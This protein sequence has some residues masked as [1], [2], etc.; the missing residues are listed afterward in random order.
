[1]RVI[2]FH[3]SGTISLLIINL[4]ASLVLRASASDWPQWR[5][6]HRDGKSDETG[7]LRTWPEKGPE[8]LWSIEGIGRGH[9]SPS[10]KDNTVYVTGMIDRTDYLQ[11][12]ST[13]GKVLWKIPIGRGWFE[14]EK[15]VRSTPT[16]DGERI[17]VISGMGEI[18]CIDAVKAEAVWT[19]PAFEKFRGEHGQW[20]I[21]ESLLLIDGKVIYTP[22]GKET[23]MVALDKKTGETVWKSESLPDYTGYV[24]PIQILWGGRKIIAN[25]TA[26]YI[27][28]VDSQ[29][30]KILWKYRYSDLDTPTWHPDA[31]IINIPTPIFHQGN[32]YVT[33][34][35]DHVGVMFT[36]SGDAT[37]LEFVWKDATLDCHHGGVVLVDGYI[38]G[39]NWI[40]NARGN[41]VCIE[42]KTGKTLYETK[43]QT[44]GSI[45]YADGRLYCYEE[46]RGIMALVKP[47]P[48]KFS[49]VSQ[50]RVEAGAGPHWAHPA[51]SN[52]ILYIRHGDTLTAYDI[53]E[54]TK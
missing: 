46:R 28:G 36:L 17:Y 47:D 4:I 21:A 14:A 42:W 33:S 54:P 3:R 24:S 31:P 18:S 19:V 48:K 12:I 25:V 51:I 30:G 16:V 23:T 20:G 6:L 13:E 40:D 15:G 26:N 53:K 9:S 35:Y 7:L 50:F 8:I 10:V 45:I 5:G 38:Y 49:I 1:M 52:G 39:S 37:D 44:K 43:W 22:A 11:A 34:G 41:W 32:L 2:K 29:D 27:F